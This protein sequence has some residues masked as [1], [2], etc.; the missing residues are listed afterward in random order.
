VSSTGNMLE[1]SS[2]SKRPSFVG[3]TMRQYRSVTRA[4]P[5]KAKQ[6]KFAQFATLPK[7]LRRVYTAARRS[8]A[9]RGASLQVYA[10]ERAQLT[11]STSASYAVDDKGPGPGALDNFMKLPVEQYAV[12]EASEI[13]RLGPNLFELKGPRM[14]FFNIWVEPRLRVTVT[15]DLG[16]EDTLPSVTLSSDTAEV[17]GSDFVRSLNSKFNIGWTTKLTWKAAPGSKGEISGDAKLNLDTEVIA[18]FSLMPRPAFNA[19]VQA[20]L[21]SMLPPVLGIFMS[22]LGQDYTKW[23]SDSDYRAARIKQGQ[24]LKGE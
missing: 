14:E 22:R 5:C 6:Y 18:P 8:P 21:D 2:A 24:Q 1:R 12:L 20:V 4:T 13:Q 17:D 16:D 10:V 23:A 15:Q 3:A 7:E 11:A 19:S 9:R